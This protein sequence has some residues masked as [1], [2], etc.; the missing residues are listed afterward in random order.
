MTLE[1]LDVKHSADRFAAA[2][3]RNIYDFVLARL[4]PGS[5][6]LEV[7][8][9]LGGF[10]RELFPK[11]GSYTG[12]E[13]DPKAGAEAR[14]KTGGK[15][16]IIQADA[17]QLPFANGQF[18]FIVCLEVLEH[19]G[20]WQAGVRHI[21]RCLQPEG[22]VIISVP[23]RRIGGRSKTNEYHIYEPGEGELVSL[24]KELFEKV[25]VHYQYFEESYGMTLAR[26]LHIRRW[27]GLASNYGD[28]S[29]G[30]PHALSKLH[31]N[32]QPKGLKLGVILVASGAKASV[33]T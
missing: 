4:A 15:A 30:L 22:Q 26:N 27:V 1:R 20:D 16:E 7:G 31:I 14:Q 19:L 29:A 25:E 11:C 12:V 2:L 10:T 13:I 17:R 24:F 23:Y 21:H 9:G 18:S 32:Q 6:V 5:R 33:K 28:L 3:H 8:T